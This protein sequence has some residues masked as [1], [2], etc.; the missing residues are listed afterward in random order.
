[1][2]IVKRNTRAG[3]FIRGA[4]FVGYFT[5]TVTLISIAGIVL[6]S[7]ITPKNDEIQAVILAA[8]LGA[9]I[10]VS[11]VMLTAMSPVPKLVSFTLTTSGHKQLQDA[12]YAADAMVEKRIEEILS[13]SPGAVVSARTHN[14]YSTRLRGKHFVTISSTITLTRP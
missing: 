8:T 3:R 4:L 13:E 6:W 5:M 10:S 11:N 12:Y 14:H 2:N 1:M 7:S 9:I